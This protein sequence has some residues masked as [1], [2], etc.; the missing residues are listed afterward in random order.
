[1]EAGLR[2]KMDNAAFEDDPGEL[3]RILRDLADKVENGVT[4]GDQFVARDINGNK[5]GSLEIVA[6]PRAAH[7]M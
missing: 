3:A 1:V 7:K 2:I 6:E 5:V 4:D